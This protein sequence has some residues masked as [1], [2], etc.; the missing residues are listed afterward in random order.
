M[1]VVLCIDLRITFFISKKFAPSRDEAVGII[2][3]A[4][5]RL[6]ILFSEFPF[7]GLE[8]PVAAGGQSIDLGIAYKLDRIG[9][10]GDLAEP[11]NTLKIS[12]KNFFRVRAEKQFKIF[13]AIECKL[14]RGV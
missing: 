6:S 10:C 5:N 12:L 11:N 2:C 9:V 4:Q 8:M 13:T 1:A 3:T 7:T 14:K